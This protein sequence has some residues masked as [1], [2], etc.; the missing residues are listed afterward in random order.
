[1]Q[2]TKTAPL[3]IEIGTEELPA[4]PFLQEL[5]HIHT[6]FQKILEKNR[7]EAEFSFFYTPRRLVILSDN[8]PLAQNPQSL[9]FFG[10]PLSIAFKDSTPTQA[11][12]SFFKKCGITQEEATTNTK[13][14]KEVLYCKKDALELRAESLLQNIIKE[15]LESLNFGKTM[16]WG[17]LQESFI[18]PIS[19]ILCLLDSKLV[20]INLYAIESK[21][22]T[23]VHR[24][25]SFEAFDIKDNKHYLKTLENNG[26]ILD[27][28]KRKDKIL[29]EIKEIE[30]KKGIKVEL[31]NELLEEVVAITEY[32]TALLGEFSEH[33]LE[34]PAPCIITSMKVNQR[35]FATYKNNQ[36]YNGFIVVS[37]SLS[38]NFEKIINGNIKVLR[39]RL[40]DA[41]FFY[42]ND[43][44]SGFLVD[45]LHSVT[46]VEGLGSMLDKTEREEKIAKILFE[47]FY[48]DFTKIA[49]RDGI[50]TSV[51]G[52][53]LTQSVHLSKA[54]LM[55]EMVYEFT[56]LQGIMGY[57]YAKALNYDNKIALA[58]KEQ[59]LP[60]SEESE[61]PSNL[62][63]ACVAL[64]Y[65]L[66]NLLSLFSI[67]KIPSGSRDPF[68]LRR[69]ANGVIKIILHFDLSFNISSILKELAKN[70]NSFNLQLLENFI[71]ERLE[72]YFSQNK[73]F[74]N[75]NPSLLR[76]VLE[77]GERDLKE[78]FAKLQALDSTLNS[79]DKTLLLQTFKRL[80]NSIKDI[81]LNSN[82]EVKE[83]SLIA[84]EELELYLA[85]KNASAKECGYKEHLE[86]FLSLSPILERFFDK[87]LVNA[88]DEAF[89]NNRK[90]LIARIYKEF[91]KIAD[92]KE[93]SF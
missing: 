58:I 53:M 60:N 33:F 20:P 79:Q 38:K 59:Y 46:F 74:N 35:Y 70:Y 80:A 3:L 31:D 21:A 78:I 14:G 19:W 90:H 1:M 11:A 65:K 83:E 85:Y 82:L 6:K 67:N 86:S 42:H 57:Y 92:I 25:I 5:P 36:L 7:L 12:L 56:E 15:F 68:A 52:E 77:T 51:L 69:A 61:L 73:N 39:A 76:A 81:D 84:S 66:D 43:L 26:V 45:K 17:S 10:P 93:I 23:F 72:S 34:L 88:P 13:D 63:S 4:I 40:E 89:R 64:S 8:F 29:S 22:Q 18:R 24:N 87:V 9:E 47:N 27:P 54:D 71:F 16:R 32:P 50:T 55:S 41:L 44:K 30:A 48:N 75:F 49:E 2:H 91:L 28:Q 62:L 37:N